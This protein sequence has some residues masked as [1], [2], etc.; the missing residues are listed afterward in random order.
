LHSDI[1]E[2]LAREKEAMRLL[3]V[4]HYNYYRNFET[5]IRAL[6]MIGQS[7][8]NKPLRLFLTCEFTSGANPGS[9]DP[10]SIANLIKETGVEE[11]VIQLGTV[12]YSQLHHL[13][14]QCHIYVT[15]AYAETFAHPLVEAMA[16]GLPLVASDLAV[17]REICGNAAVY[18]D[19]F[20][21]EMLAKCVAEVVESK[22]LA[23]RMSRAGQ[24]RSRQ[25]SWQAHVDELLD[26]ARTL[27]ATR[28][29]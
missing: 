5:L 17:H 23:E 20:S 11:Q 13:Y 9:Y 8:K 19:R 27:A 22:A 15:P 3:F 6:P 16:S 7:V 29:P 2:K 28:R 18:F 4:S 25:F 12:P 26:L 10:Q 24:E 14:R 21:P 1:A